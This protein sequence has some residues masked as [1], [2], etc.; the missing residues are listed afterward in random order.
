MLSGFMITRRFAHLAAV[1]LLPLLVLACEKVPLLAPSGSTIILTSSTNVLPVNGT[2]DIVAQVLEAA[3]TPP[4][5]GTVISLTTTLGSIEPADARTD[6]SGRVVVKFRAGVSNGAATIT[7]TS[8]GATTGTTGA[9]RISI[10]TAAVASV[11]LSASPNPVSA[12]GG[13]ATVTANVI[14]MNGNAL[15]SVPVRFSTTAGTLGASVASTDASGVAQTSLTTSAQATVTATVGAQGTTTPPPSSGGGT[16]TPPASTGTASATIQ[17]NVNPLPNVQITA[18][19]GTLIA[20]TPLI[21]TI[22]AQPGPNSTAQIRNVRVNFGDGDIVDLGA[23]SGTGITVAHQYD[24]DGTYQ[25]RVTVT[26]TL[27]GE[28]QAATVIVVQPQPPLGVTINCTKSGSL[29]PA[30]SGVTASCT[31][32]VT[33]STATVSS[34]L[35]NWGDGSPATTTTSNQAVHQYTAAGTFTVTVT[36]TTTT[37]QTAVGQT[38]V[39]IP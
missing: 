18:P 32:T 36:V 16:T 23:V 3:G 37:G 9:I 12:N 39:A 13:V 10:G 5:S 25:V 28:T 6:V 4:H 29:P 22:T 31:A 20:R 30:G 7:A 38:A 34:Y 2:A 27:G 33:P 15:P 1:G 8:G 21:F 19:T 11:S 17:V 26:D 14:D 35:W 24:D